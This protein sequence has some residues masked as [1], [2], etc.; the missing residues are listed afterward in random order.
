ISICILCMLYMQWLCVCVLG[1]GGKTENKKEAD[2][3]VGSNIITTK[4][5]SKLISF[6]LLLWHNGDSHLV[7]YRLSATTDTL[8]TPILQLQ[9]PCDED[10]SPYSFQQF[11]D[12]QNSIPSDSPHFQHFCTQWKPLWE[13]VTQDEERVYVGTT[14][15][16]VYRWELT[17]MKQK[18]D[19]YWKKHVDDKGIACNNNNNNNNSNDEN[20]AMNEI[21]T[22]IGSLCG[23]VENGFP[24]ADMLVTLP[25]KVE[26]QWST[27]FHDSS[28]DPSMDIQFHQ[29]FVSIPG[30]QNANASYAEILIE[31]SI[32]QQQQ[33]QANCTVTSSSPLQDNK[34]HEDWPIPSAAKEKRRQDDVRATTMKITNAGALLCFGYGSGEVYVYNVSEGEPVMEIHTQNAA[35]TTLLLQCADPKSVRSGDGILFV[36]YANGVVEALNTKFRYKRNIY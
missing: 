35:V 7:M 3:A 36:G 31:G 9:V 26:S 11:S 15:G 12:I 30:Q 13:T 10:Q 1:G 17:E 20:I 18:G 23:C 32:Q 21:P 19:E 8:I 27:P 16:K 6:D 24:E 5:L 4:V 2:K 14:N 25:A 29:S 33:Q 28:A 22:I 34:D